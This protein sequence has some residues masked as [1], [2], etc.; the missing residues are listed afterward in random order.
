VSLA[1]L[2]TSFYLTNDVYHPFIILGNYKPLPPPP[3]F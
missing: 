3:F 2:T 1:Y